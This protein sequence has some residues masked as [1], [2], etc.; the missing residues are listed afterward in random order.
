MFESEMAAKQAGAVYISDV[1]SKFTW[2]AT[3]GF[4]SFIILSLFLMIGIPFCLSQ[5]E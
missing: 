2:W 4:Y 3:F 1:H 5:S